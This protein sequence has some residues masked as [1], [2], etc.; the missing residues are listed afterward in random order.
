MMART[1]RRPGGG[2]T[3]AAILD[4]ARRAFAERGY[5]HA[6]IRAV[7]EAA[8]VDPALVHHYFG[9]KERLF[10]AAMD[11]PV[12]PVGIVA[13]LLD[14]DRERIGE[15]IVGTF[16]SVWDQTANRN[17]LIALIRS[18]VSSDRAAVM[19]RE[20]ILRE[21]FGRITDRLGMPD[22]RLRASL[23][24]SQ[25]MGLAVARYIVGLDPIASASPAELV[26]TIGPTI[27]RYVTGDIRAEA[28]R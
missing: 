2:G 12:D 17:P 1:G 8:R 16:V 25:L 24:A 14:G 21:L 20:F 10:V 13:M 11:L 27:Q 3:R 15:R 5:D 19:L 26:A 6:T 22:S 7:A 9:S 18:A 23:V 4:A 28:G